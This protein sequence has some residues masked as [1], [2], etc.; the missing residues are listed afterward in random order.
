MPLSPAAPRKH[1]H[2]RT[3]QCYGYEREDGMW[4]IEGHL[5]DTKSYTFPN[6]HR[7]QVKAGEPV[8]EM[9]LRLTVDDDLVVHDVEA[10]TDYGPYATCPDITPHFARLKG[11]RIGAGLHR[12]IHK[13]V[14]G[15][16]GCTHLVEL[17]RPLATAAYQTLVPLK[18]ERG[19]MN[20]DP[21]KRP[22]IIDTCH[23]YASDGEVVKE[24]WPAFYTGPA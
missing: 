14:G 24:S 8:H 3:V 16:L 13:R 9:W 15:I 17:L 12:E 10:V 1:I 20:T 22:A 11:L 7:G 21:A 5:V 4:D 19:Q 6:R 2:T 18:V 23:V